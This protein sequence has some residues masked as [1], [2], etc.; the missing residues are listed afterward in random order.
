MQPDNRYI[1][2]LDGLRGY[3]IFLVLLGHLYVT[4]IIVAQFGVTVFFFVSGFLITK[5]LIYEFDRSRTIHLKDFYLRRIF[6]LYPALL[7]MLISYCVVMLSFGYRVIWNDIIAGLFYFTNY[8]LVYF[9]P[10]LPDAKYLLVS[11]ILWS[12]SV[13]EHFYVVFPLLFAILFP[14]GRKLLV[15]LTVLVV[16]VLL[17]RIYPP[18]SFNECYYLTHCRADSILFGCISALLI[19]RYDA[20]WYLKLLRS[21]GWFYAGLGLLVLALSWRN[22]FFQRTIVYSIQGLGLFLVVPSF[23]FVNSRGWVRRFADN[24][25]SVYL[26]KL[27]YS[28][29]LFHWVALQVGILLFPEKSPEWYGVVVPLTIGLPLLS[30]YFVEKPFIRLRRRFGSNVKQ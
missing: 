13:E 27:S 9:P 14:R 24:P 7:V 30:F 15:L 1:S 29:Y 18:R 12:L 28:I 5:L 17:V 6:R 8:Y 26:G 25:V 22:L 2:Y 11:K 21:R 19:Y 20:G 4:K 3:A 16:V 23:S 10:V